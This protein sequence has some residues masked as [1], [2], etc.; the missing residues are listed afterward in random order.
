MQRT[1]ERGE[2]AAPVADGPVRRPGEHAERFG[3]HGAG[4]DQVVGHPAGEQPVVRTH[5]EDVIG[6]CPTG[7]DDV[8]DDDTGPFALGADDV[9]VEERG[10]QPGGRPRAASQTEPIEL[11]EQRED[12][13][14]LLGRVE[15]PVGHALPRVE[16]PLDRAAVRG[17]PCL[18]SERQLGPVGGSA[19]RVAVSSLQP[20]E[21]HQAAMPAVVD[22]LR[23]ELERLE[24]RPLALGDDAVLHRHAVPLVGEP[25]DGVDLAV[26][27]DIVPERCEPGELDQRATVEAVDR[28][29]EQQPHDLAGDGALQRGAD[30]AARGDVR[31]G[32]RGR[33]CCA[34]R[35][36]GREEDGDPV[37]H[38]P[39]IEQIDD[40]SGDLAHLFVV[41][42][43]R[44]DRDRRTVRPVVRRHLDRGAD[45]GRHVRSDGQFGV[46]A[47][48][49]HHDGARGASHE[50][51]QERDVCGIELLRDHEHER[52]IEQLGPIGGEQAIDRRAE[53]ER[54][55]GEP[56]G[57]QLGAHLADDGAD[58]RCT[59]PT[60]TQVGEHRLVL[61]GQGEHPGEGGDRAHDCVVG[62]RVVGARGE[63]RWPRRLIGQHPLH[64]GEHRDRWCGPSVAQERG[65][66]G[67]SEAQRATDLGP[68]RPAATRQRTPQPVDR[69]AVGR[70]H[71]HERQRIVA[72]QHPH[73]LADGLDQRHAGSRHAH[74]G[75]E[76]CRPGHASNLPP[77]C[78]AVPAISERREIEQQRL[79]EQRLVR[80]PFERLERV[81]DA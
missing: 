44:D 55:V 61:A 64:R 58:R 52:G 22:R 50:R 47:A 51:S 16:P 49:R 42:G 66:D 65:G 77:A 73:G 6:N 80:V 15:L 62:G 72:L 12:S 14:D 36:G 75:R 2:H 19:H 46:A 68:A 29:R 70:D 3:S 30:L 59:R 20:H 63:Q 17:E 31:C 18:E 48:G 81:V 11:A 45:D 78:D 26:G 38:H 35:P 54:G 21:P 60:T 56:G 10:D 7:G 76:R 39:V 67:S 53:D 71:P 28:E 32:E 4:E 27:I 24:H 37:G 8:V 13:L 69:C 5:H 25:R 43:A 41:V 40:A 34:V 23:L 1:V 57:E 9:V 74:L 79:E 33:E